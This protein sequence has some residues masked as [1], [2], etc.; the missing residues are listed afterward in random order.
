MMQALKDGNP[1]GRGD[2][3][4][5]DQNPDKDNC[6]LHCDSV[7]RSDTGEYEIVLKNELGEVKVP[8]TIKVLGK[9]DLPLLLG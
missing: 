2:P 5:V 7:R 4:K 1:L 3:M 6:K 8:I 9:F